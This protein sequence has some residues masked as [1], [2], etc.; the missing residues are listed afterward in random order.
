MASIKR[1]LQKLIPV[2]AV[3]GIYLFL[4]SFSMSH[5]L[6]L[7]SNRRIC[8]QRRCLDSSSLTHLIIV[9]GHSVL[10]AL[11]SDFSSESSWFLQDYQR[12][13]LPTLLKHMEAAVTLAAKDASSLLI[14]SGGQTRSD[15]VPISEG[16][17]YWLACKYR[18]N[19]TT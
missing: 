10:S 2:S 13:Q 16:L 17:S 18:F 19:I 11:V 6:I 9:P 12:D 3:I 5:N 1:R 4:Y 15:S 7:S 14:F 8:K